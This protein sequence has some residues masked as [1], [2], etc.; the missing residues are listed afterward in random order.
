MALR[1]VR[2]LKIPMGFAAS[3]RINCHFCRLQN[4]HFSSVSSTSWLVFI[5]SRHTAAGHLDGGFF[6]Q[7]LEDVGPPMKDEI[8]LGFVV[9]R[10]P[11]RCLMSSR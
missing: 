7:T 10:R 2:S 5:S 1:G 4:C 6:G 11:S 3:Q 9:S 8:N